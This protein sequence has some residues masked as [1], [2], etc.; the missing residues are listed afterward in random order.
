G[1]ADVDRH[2]VRSERRERRRPDNA[3]GIVMLLERAGH[4]ARD[5]DAV[6]A[7]F[8]GPLLTIGAQEA[9]LHGLR[10]LRPQVE[11][12][13]DLDAAVAHEAAAFAPG[14]RVAGPRLPQIDEVRAPEVARLV[15]THHVLVGAI[16][17]A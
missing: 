6:A 11:H 5:A 1:V 7:H 16:A 12:L 13:T 17:T 10:V 9:H 4:G 15:D 14:A 3:R 2:D 8:H